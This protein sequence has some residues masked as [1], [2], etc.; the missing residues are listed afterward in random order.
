MFVSIH[1]KER[2]ELPEGSTAKDLADKLNLKGPAEAIG[3]QV[4][5]KAVDLSHPLQ[6]KDTAIFFHSLP[7]IFSIFC[8]EHLFLN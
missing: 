8:S 3:V 6:D 7:P 5:G 1:N 4:N 2:V